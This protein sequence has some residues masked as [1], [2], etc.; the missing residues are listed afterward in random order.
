MSD[1]QEAERLLSLNSDEKKTSRSNLFSVIQ[2]GA[3]FTILFLAYNTA[4]GF[5]SSVNK[6]LGLWSLS[7]LY[8]VFSFSNL[9]AG[10]IVQKLGEKLSLFFG[11]LGYVI[12]LAANVYPT[13]YTLIP[14][15]AVIG[16]G[17]AVLWTAQGSFMAKCSTEETLGFHSG[18][19]FGLFQ[20]NAVI[21]NLLAALLLHLGKSVHVV[22][23]VL[24]ICGVAADLLLLLLKNPSTPATTT[25]TTKS[26]SLTDTLYMFKDPKML[27][28][29]ITLIYSGF[30]QSFFFSKFPQKIKEEYDLSMVAF[31]MVAFGFADTLGSVIM[32]RLS[33]KVGKKPVLILATIS[34][35]A[36]YVLT[37]GVIIPLK[38][39][40]IFFVIAVLMGISDAGYNTQLYSVIGL[41]QPTKLEAAYAFL[42]GIQATSTA[43]A[44][45]YST[46]WDLSQISICMLVTNVAGIAAFII[47]DLFVA[48]VDAETK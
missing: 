28:M 1:P 36:S 44:F 39:A 35:L 38:E 40:Y 15:A 33:D 18:V 41:F 6:N 12:F 3:T 9:F 27:L 10:A 7:V 5:E 47:C 21:G 42:K 23:I 31:V 22:F 19:F 48:K 8:F 16:L 11:A 17:A 14:G 32:G 29:M 25:N 43:I 37:L 26:V 24:L 46:F 2:L 20:M 45:L 30:S 34:G 13:F 4:Q